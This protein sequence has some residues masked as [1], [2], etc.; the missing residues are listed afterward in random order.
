MSDPNSQPWFHGRISRKEAEEKLKSTKQADGTYLL[1]ESTTAGGSYVLS[2][3][4]EG[5]VVHYQIQRKRDGTVGIEDGPQFPGPVELVHHHEVNL[6]GLLTRLTIGCK[7]P[8]GVKAKAYQNISHDDL[9]EA[10]RHALAEE[11]IQVSRYFELRMTAL[12]P[13]FT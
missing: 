11:G 12:Y 5:K 4:V 13:P 9:E 3:C 1:R 7:R 2:V 8:R 10:T 6:D